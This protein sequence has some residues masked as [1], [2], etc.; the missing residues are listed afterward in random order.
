[1]SNASAA[2]QGATILQYA[3]TSDGQQDSGSSNQVV[4]QAASGDMQAYQFRTAP[5]S[6]IAPGVVMASS[7]AL[8]IQGA[9]VEVTR[10]RVVRL[11]KNREAARECRRK[12]KEYVKLYLLYCHK[13][14]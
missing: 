5:T 2:Q 13:S 12:K 1:M 9:T 7:P 11:M 3:Q 6:T 14:E 8:P 10:K 4:V